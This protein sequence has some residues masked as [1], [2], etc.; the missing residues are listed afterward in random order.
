MHG[1]GRKVVIPESDARSPNGVREPRLAVL[2]GVC[3]FVPLVHVETQPDHAQC[4]TT[5]VA[6]DDTAVFL[7]PDPGVVAIAQSILDVVGRSN[8]VKMP[9]P[10][11]AVGR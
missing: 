9:P 4:T 10:H 3:R 2:Q 5:G 8:A 7:Y 6:L 1:V 11:F